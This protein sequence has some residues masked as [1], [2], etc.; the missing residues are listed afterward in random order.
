MTG[1]RNLALAG[2]LLG[3]A[4]VLAPQT[5][6]AGGARHTTESLERIEAEISSLDRIRSDNRRERTIA[7]LDRELAELEARSHRQ[8][9]RQA[10][11]NDVRVDQLQ[12][13]L[14]RSAERLGQTDGWHSGSDDRSRR[15]KARR[16]SERLDR[17]AQDV[18]N[19]RDIRN[20]RRR[21]AATDEVQGR[22]ARLE[23]RNDGLR[24]RLARRNAARI[25]ELQRRAARI[26]RR[27]ERRLNERRH[28]Y[29]DGG[30]FQI[31]IPL[32]SEGDNDNA[33]LRFL[34]RQERAQNG[35]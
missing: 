32:A 23:R 17:V 3:A 8:R 22:L 34:H 2:L 16:I 1:Y 33:V 15:G 4:S 30:S 21:L 28:R 10:R 11:R 14:A 35:R 13:A 12:G 29:S 31:T 27:A 20:Q 18:S 9:G 24:G 7:R 5:A 26:E 6:A 19:L 25:D